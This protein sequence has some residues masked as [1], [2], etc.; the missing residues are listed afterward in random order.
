SRLYRTNYVQMAVFRRRRTRYQLLTPPRSPRRAHRGTANRPLPVQW[1]IA[2]P[3][4]GMQ[5]E[6]RLYGISPR[7]WLPAHHGCFLLRRGRKSADYEQCFGG[8]GG[9]AAAAVSVVA[10]LAGGSAGRRR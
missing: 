7:E 2:M 8:F 3:S 1:T 6:T 9:Q 10:D 5:E 4:N